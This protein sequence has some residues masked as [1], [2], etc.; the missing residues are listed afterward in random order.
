MASPPKPWERAG[1]GGTSTGMISTDTAT[2]VATATAADPSAPAI[3]QRPSALTSAVN[4][5]ASAYST[6]NRPYGTNTY[7][8]YGSGYG[9]GSY[10]SYSSPYNRFGSGMYGGGMYGSGYG[11][12]GMGGMYGGGMYGGGMYGQGMPGDPNNPQSLTQ[13]FGQSTQATFQLIEGIVGAFFAESVRDMARV[14]SLSFRLVIDISTILRD[15]PLDLTLTVLPRDRPSLL[16]DPRLAPH[17]HW[18]LV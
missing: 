2:P 12:Y 3:P 8:G 10:S 5:N 7:G 1:A 16:Q 6:M 15:C 18:S 4:Q 14:D 17:W 11:G 9:M 13:S